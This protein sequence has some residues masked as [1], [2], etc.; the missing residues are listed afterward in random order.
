MSLREPG[1]C[2]E[3]FLIWRCLKRGPINPSEM[4]RN[5]E[6]PASAAPHEF[7]QRNG[8]NIAALGILRLVAFSSRLIGGRGCPWTVDKGY[9][10]QSS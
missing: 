7:V 10:Y 6:R 1:L 4:G 3:H 9:S 5:G 8:R 2:K